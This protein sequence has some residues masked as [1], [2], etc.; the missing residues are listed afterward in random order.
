MSATELDK[1][2]ASTAKAGD[3][4]GL[5]GVDRSRL[6]LLAAYTGL[7]LGSL[8]KLT[9]ESFAVV[10]GVVQ[11]VTARAETTKKRKLHVVPLPKDV[12]GIVARWL[13]GKTPGERLWPCKFHRGYGSKLLQFDLSAAGI[14]FADASGAVFDFH[15]LRGQYATMLVR[16]GVSGSVVTRLMDHSD[17]KLTAKYTK[18]AQTDLIHAVESLPNLGAKLGTV[19]DNKCEKGL[20]RTKKPISKKSGGKIEKTGILGK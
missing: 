19:N 12:G 18:L 10:A 4:Y 8:I 6:Y 11:S 9:V 5:S 3:R 14:P 2:I 7:R 16:A 1:L 20:S 17:P 13:A 15:A